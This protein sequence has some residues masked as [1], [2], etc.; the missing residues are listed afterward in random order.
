MFPVESLVNGS[1]DIVSIELLVANCAIGH[2]AMNLVKEELRNVIILVLDCVEKIALLYVMICN[3]DEVTEIFFGTEDEEGA[4]FI[5]L[6]D[7]E[8]VFEMSGLDQWM[9]TQ[10]AAESQLIKFIECPKCRTPIRRSLR[11]GNIIKRTVND[12]ESVKKLNL[13]QGV[14]TTPQ[15]LQRL[16][17]ITK[18]AMKNESVE[19]VC[20]NVCARIDNAICLAQGKPNVPP[21]LP[22]HINTIE[23]QINLLNK[24]DKL[25]ECFDPLKA[26]KCQFGSGPLV[27]CMDTVLKEAMSLLNFLKAEYLSP[28]Q[29]KDAECELRRLF[30]LSRIC[31]I[32]HNARKEGKKFEAAHEGVLEQQVE[33]YITSGV[34]D[35]KATAEDQEKIDE[36]LEIIRKQYSIGELT[37]SERMEIVKAMSDIQAGGWYKCRNGHIY[38]IGDCGGATQTGECPDC[39]S[40]IG[41]TGHRLETGNTHAGEMDGSQHA[42][43]SE[44]ANLA[45]FD[46]QQLKR[47][48]SLRIFYET[49]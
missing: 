44:G 43:W 15:E 47:I 33:F 22:Q 37:E 11:Y 21:L 26:I 31:Q 40:L 30:C 16:A 29:A 25:F 28:Q 41:G 4:R 42:A 38:A 27:V 23:N 46:Q 36:V 2:L 14:T 39:G 10:N 35:R 34:T 24:L 6:K 19:E 32:Q 8:H 5:Q 48:V 13:S 7:C 9:E 12:M 3:K 20:I 49:L 1:E 17:K 18:T 45:N